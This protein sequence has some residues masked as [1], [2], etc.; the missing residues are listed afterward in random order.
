MFNGE[1]GDDYFNGIDHTG[2]DAFAG[3]DGNDWLNYRRVRPIS[4][5]LNDVADDGENC[6]GASCEGDNAGSDIENLS[7]GSVQDTLA[8]NER[9]NV[10]T[11]EG[12]SDTLI[13]FGGDDELLGDWGWTAT[14]GSRRAGRRTDSVARHRPG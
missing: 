7:G 9:D 3:G 10:I 5:S 14:E 8:G 1:G 13:G 11:G 4:V 6:P 2:A 12:G